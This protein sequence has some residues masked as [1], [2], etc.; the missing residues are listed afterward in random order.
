MRFL[1]ILSIFIISKTVS[2]NITNDSYELFNRKQV[3]S[4]FL[5]QYLI[6]SID[7]KCGYD[8]LKCLSYCSSTQGCISAIYSKLNAQ[9]GY[10]CNL[11]NEMPNLLYETNQ[12]EFSNL[13]IKTSKF[14]Y[15]FKFF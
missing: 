5:N 2:F 15:C 10:K 14:I 9:S 12:T 7:E 8:P 6:K 4:P 13:Y 1:L 11:F 3:I